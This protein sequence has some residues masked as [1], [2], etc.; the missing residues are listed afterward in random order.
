MATR[1]KVRKLKVFLGY[2]SDNS[3]ASEIIDTLA[4]IIEDC[5]HESIKSDSPEDTTIG[6][7]GFNDLIEKAFFFD[8]AIIF[9]HKD[10][11]EDSNF[12]MYIQ[13]AIFV[14]AKD[15]SKVLLC[16][17]EKLQTP[18][19]LCGIS[20]I[21]WCHKKINK[22]KQIV[23]NWLREISNSLISKNITNSQLRILKLIKERT[24]KKSIGHT[25]DSFLKKYTEKHY[26]ITPLEYTNMIE[27]FLKDELVYEHTICNQQT[28]FITDKGID[29]IESECSISKYTGLTD[30]DGNLDEADMDLK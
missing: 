30:K 13:Y 8:G 12:N 17:D 4:Q 9:L 25:T 5:D 14:G 23:R 24:H 10:D 3:S 29:K 15:F 6:T 1:N 20:H 16:I 26:D 22:N 21:T 2:S 28:F 19:Q 11:S 18:S 7:N 27:I